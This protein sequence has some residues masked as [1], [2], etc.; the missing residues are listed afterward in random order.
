MPSHLQQSVPSCHSLA[1]PV[2]CESP[3]RNWSREVFSSSVQELAGV[4]KEISSRT[5]RPRKCVA[6]F[7]VN[8]KRRLFFFLRKK[9]L[10]KI[11]RIRLVRDNTQRACF[12]K[13]HIIWS[14]I[15]GVTVI[16]WTWFGEQHLAQVEAGRLGK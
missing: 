15:I 16:V 1:R 9:P 8:R 3:A 12:L 5:A 7:S 14:A 4:A 10:L 2:S 6:P 13:V 11:C